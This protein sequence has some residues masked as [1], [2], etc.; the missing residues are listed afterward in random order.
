[1][2]RR[3]PIRMTLQPNGAAVFEPA[4]GPPAWPTPMMESE[5]QA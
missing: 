1:M 5:Q 4:N 2:P 3:P